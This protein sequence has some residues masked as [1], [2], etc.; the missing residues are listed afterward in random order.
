MTTTVAD[1]T[2]RIIL[3]E[4]DST[5]GWTGSTGVTAA[6]A[7][8]A[9]EATNQLGMGV[10]TSTDD[11]FV[12]ITLD[13]YAGGGT[14]SVWVQANGNMDTLVNGGIMVQV[15]DGT[16]RIGYHVGGS[17]QSAFRH[18]AGPVKW[19]CYLLDLANKPANNTAFA[20]SE[21]SLNET[22]ITNVG[23][24]FKTLSKALGGGDNCYWDIIRFADNGD[25]VTFVGGTTS[26]AAGNGA[27]ATVL[28]RAA[29]NQQA[30][31]VIRQLAVGVYGI[32]GNINL[33]DST[34]ASDQFWTEANVTYAWEDRGLSSNNYYRFALIGSSTATNC[35]FSFTSVTF[36]VPSAASAS[37]DGNGADITVANMFSCSFIG[38]DQG[39]ETS[40]DTGDDWTNST[41]I[42]NGQVV[43]NGCDMSGSNVL[44]SVVAAGSGALLYNES[45]DPDGETDD[46]TFSQG[47]TA[48]S[49]YEFGTSVTSDITIRGNDFTGFGSTDDVNGAVFK[50]LATSGSLNLNLIGCTTDGSFSVDDSAGI[51]VT[52]VIDP[53]TVTINVK[54]NQGNNLQNVRVFLETAATVASGEEFEGANTS[55]TQS[56]GVATCTQ[57]GV[58]DL[59]TGDLIVVRDA[60]PDGYNKVATAT[61]T[62]T[63]VFTY[64]VDSGLSTPATGT[65][66]VSYVAIQELTSAGGDAN[67][68]RTF[69][70]SQAFKGWAR[71]KNT[72]SPFYKEAPL[73][74]TIDATNGNT[75]N[76]VLQPD[77]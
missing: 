24:G 68:S 38:F 15:T 31:G 29:T 70:A 61:V 40:D 10:S 7:P 55:L 57:T 66:I 13:N 19:E 65:P 60:Q 75:V 73:A 23:V 39:I 14:L 41:Y 67:V 20:G 27:E 30:L 76:V 21:A 45:V 37:F 46:M 63:T 56:A 1:D 69:G 36:T 50:F 32:Q 34:S 5:S 18:D 4:C 33:G 35:E 64:P 51:T 22:S 9:I 3:N 52:V 16:N 71:L 6:N 47:A 54:D 43:F 58:H 49:A 48:H 59:E 53:V 26:G 17:D 8:L 77:E 25:A 28:D 2:A 44:T 11:A 12:A 62:S 72:S 74:F 42:S